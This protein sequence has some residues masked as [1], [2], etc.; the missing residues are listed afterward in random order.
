MYEYAAKIER[1]IDGDTLL[2]MVDLGFSC[3]REERIRLAR[4]NAWELKSESAYQRRWAKS[5]TFQAKKLFP[6]GSEIIIQTK[7]NPL[8]DMYAR[9][10][11]EVVCN[12]ANVS[13]ALLKLKG[14][15]VFPLK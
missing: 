5:V 10:I 15:V 11:A 12:G 6:N 14:V 2:V 8:K 4:I 1:W 13:D 9:Y 3:F 7:K